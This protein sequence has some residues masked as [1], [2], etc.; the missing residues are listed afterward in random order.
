M[1]QHVRKWGN[2]AAVRIPAR[3]LAEAGLKPGDAVEV[4]GEKGQIVIEPARP[5]PV[6]LEW[7]LEGITP[8][9][10]HPEIDFGPPVGREFW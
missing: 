3:V 8:E 7:L 2:S 6:T 5:E 1:N 9:N 4:R 10:V